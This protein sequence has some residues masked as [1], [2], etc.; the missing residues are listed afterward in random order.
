MNIYGQKI[1]YQED[2]K[3]T[4]P[5]QQRSALATIRIHTANKT[6]KKGKVPLQ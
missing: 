6:R 4:L 5:L 3:Y 1:I 2:T